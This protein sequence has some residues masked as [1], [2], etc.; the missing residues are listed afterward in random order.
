MTKEYICTVDHAKFNT[1]EELIR[2]LLQLYS[3]ESNSDEDTSGILK[4]LTEH[5]PDSNVNVKYNNGIPDI[6]LAI[7]KY[8][9][10][11]DFKIGGMTSQLASYEISHTSI[12]EAVMRYRNML[13]KID[14]LVENVKVVFNASDVEIEQVY[15]A[16]PYGDSC[17][18]ALISFY[19]DGKQYHY[20]YGFESIEGALHRI[21][22]Y[23]IAVVEGEVETDYDGYD[24]SNTVYID[25]I[26]IRDL[27]NRAKRMRVEI[28][29]FR[30][31]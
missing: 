24:S 18:S 20:S 17:D 5:F 16:D 14:D 13:K 31:D 28:L 19:V 4:L 7:P 27:A 26:D 8:Q 10:C 29:E 1:E 21:S 23:F 3:V 30:E 6:R 9:A 12:E 15:E 22:G 25:S 2:H 11:F